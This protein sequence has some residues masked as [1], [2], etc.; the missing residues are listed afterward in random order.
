[1]AMFDKECGMETISHCRTKIQIQNSKSFISNSMGW[2]ITE[3]G[4]FAMPEYNV[5]LATF[6][7]PYI[8]WVEGKLNYHVKYNNLTIQL[9][10]VDIPEPSSIFRISAQYDWPV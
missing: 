4:E 2:R 3:S 9:Y 10:T 7:E 5:G 1:M 8:N 6:C